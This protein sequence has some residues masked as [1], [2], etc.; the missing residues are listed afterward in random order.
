MGNSKEELGEKLR[1]AGLLKESKFIDFL[2][3]R[4]RGLA[5][6][7]FVLRVAYRVLRREDS[8]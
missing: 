5:E 1:I 6:G 8:V 4:R 7:I 2:G 3:L